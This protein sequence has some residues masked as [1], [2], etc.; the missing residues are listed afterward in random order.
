ML[1][2]AEKSRS[3]ETTMSKKFAEP[4]DRIFLIAEIVAV[5]CIAALPHIYWGLER[6]IWHPLYKNVTPFTASK[7]TLMW[8]YLMM[9]IPVWYIAK[10]NESR[11]GKFNLGKIK[12]LH[13]AG[14]IGVWAIGIMVLQ[15]I[16]NL[17]NASH[18]GS[19]EST[20][21]FFG[22]IFIFLSAIA[23]GFVEE[24]VFRKYFVERFKLLFGKI[25]IAVLLSLFI[26]CLYYS[27]GKGI[28]SYVFSFI[29]G[30]VYM[31]L[32]LLLKSVWPGILGHILV[33]LVFVLKSVNV[34]S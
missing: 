25:S 1:L 32:F 6:I 8:D 2:S 10:I 11:F 34:F 30:S 22:Y 26:Y 29:I 19:P 31:C 13:F 18:S 12:P 23:T 33:D 27:F 15:E 4:S 28:S 20:I 5:L 16:A 17:K 3:I 7:M 24:I 21:S 9:I 14:G